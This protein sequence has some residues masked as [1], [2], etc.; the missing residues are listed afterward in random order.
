M[1]PA[2]SWSGCTRASRSTVSRRRRVARHRRSRTT[3]RGRQHA[4]REGRSA[5]AVGIFTELARFG[6][7][8]ARS[9]AGCCS[10]S[11]FPGGAS[12]A[13]LTGQCSAGRAK[14]GSSGSARL[15]ASAAALRLRGR[16]SAAG[17][18][19]AAGSRSP[20][21]GRPSL[22]TTGEAPR[23]RLEGARPAH[24]RRARR[25]DRGRCRRSAQRIH[26][27]VRPLRP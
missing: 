12:S 27:H 15:S 4:A 11:S 8:E 14:R 1:P 3:P 22:M 19:P 17:S 18:A 2:T 6:A 5:D 21:P 9:V 24:A 20:A 26:G 25:R 23:R 7:E 13:A 10:T 16:S